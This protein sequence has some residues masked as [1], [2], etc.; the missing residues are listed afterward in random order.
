MIQPEDLQRLK[1]LNEVTR[2][3]AKKTDECSKKIIEGLF[4]QINM[5]QKQKK[6]LQKKLRELYNDT[7]TTKN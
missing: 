6:Y 4:D 2:I 5:L 7:K 3:C 1:K